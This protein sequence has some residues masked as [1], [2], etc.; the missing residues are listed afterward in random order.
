MLQALH[1]E[2]CQLQWNFVTNEERKNEKVLSEE[3]LK[4]K[5][6]TERLRSTYLSALDEVSRLKDQVQELKGNI[7]VFCRLLPVGNGG[8]GAV[9]VFPK[10]EQMVLSQQKCRLSQLIL[11]SQQDFGGRE[12]EF[13]FDRVFS[14][15]DSQSTVYE[16]VGPLLDGIPRG[17]HLAIFAYGQ[18]GSGKTFTLDGT[19]REPGVL[20]SAL[21]DLLLLSQKTGHRLVLS[22][23]EIYNEQVRDLLQA[24]MLEEENIRL[25]CESVDLAGILSGGRVN[26]VGARDNSST[27]SR[28]NSDNLQVP[29]HGNCQS[30]AASSR[31]PSRS[32]RKPSA[33]EV[34]TT[35][36]A[37]SP[38]KHV[39]DAKVSPRKHAS[40][41]TPRSQSTSNS[42]RSSLTHAGASID[43]RDGVGGSY[44]GRAG[45]SSNFNPNNLEIRGVTGNDYTGG[46]QDHTSAS[47]SSNNP[48]ARD[49]SS[50]LFG[51]IYVENLSTQFLTDWR[52]AE[53]LL[54][55][56][57]QHR[58]TGATALNDTSSRSHCI[59]SIGMVK[60]PTHV[61]AS[62]GEGPDPVCSLP[63]YVGALHVIDLAGSERTK[64]S[65]AQGQRLQEAK[66]IN[67]SLS[68]LG[69][70]LFALEAKQAHI[71]FR[72]SKLSYLLSDVLSQS[73]S[74]VLFFANVNPAAE[75]LQETFSTL[76]FA[77]RIANIE[78]GRLKTGAS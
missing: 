3:L 34:M 37:V 55:N 31:Q 47:H 16:E 26:L 66:Q 62:E 21:Q 45:G 29:H 12:V 63:G 2:K 67:K 70:T 27:S 38:R 5:K 65:K 75:N 40:N 48:H 33:R 35:Y 22:V 9:C 20:R 41:T 44:A 10:Q 14:M 74:K 24:D 39:I 73:W 43:G 52:Q 46:S 76:A 49:F 8:E 18:T 54:K 78:K 77:R 15:H 28:K 56:A 25:S 17:F 59:Y 11:R 53:T 7:R 60:G 68:A 61:C 30:H 4:A 71:P 6:D 51:S 50:S 23:V 36:N 1:Q 64:I 42:R 13:S 69:D 72:N 32:P 19:D 58:Q 57:R